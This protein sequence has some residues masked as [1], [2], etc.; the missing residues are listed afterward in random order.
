MGGGGQEL[1]QVDKDAAGRLTAEVGARGERRA[2][3]GEC[4]GARGSILRLTSG[5]TGRAFDQWSNRARA[6]IAVE[7][8]AG[9]VESRSAC[10]GPV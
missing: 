5:Q 2:G 9:G 7:A 3:R 8:G 6:A 4:G 10:R 1:V